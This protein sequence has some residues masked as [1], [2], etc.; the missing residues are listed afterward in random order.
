[1]KS[2]DGLI[3]IGKRMLI[4]FLF[5]VIVG[6]V[7]TFV[8]SIMNSV[9]VVDWKDTPAAPHE[10]PLYKSK[11]EN[12]SIS[13]TDK[14]V[15]VYDL[16]A[17]SNLQFSDNY[18]KYLDSVAK[19]EARQELVDTVLIFVFGG[20][21]VLAVV[22]EILGINVGQMMSGANGSKRRRSV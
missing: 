20:I 9:Q 2:A 21:F 17:S 22:L 6:G 13:S 15:Y 18:Q 19:S 5:L 12:T 11:I 4:L 10:N 7:I 1:M 14:P 8:T 3:D 16:D